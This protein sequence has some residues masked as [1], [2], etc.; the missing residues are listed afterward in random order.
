METLAGLATILILAVSV[1]FLKRRGDVALHHLDRVRREH[2]EAQRTLHDLQTVVQ[3]IDESVFLLDRDERIVFLNRAAETLFSAPVNSGQSFSPIA[4]QL[5][6]QPL[7]DEILSHRAESLAQT[8]VK[9][10]R[11]FQVNVRAGPPQT[12]CA[13]MI[14]V[15]EVTELQRL[16]RVRRD[17]VANI[18]HE[19]RT[20]VTTLRLLADTLSR[21]IDPHSPAN[22]WIAKLQGQ[23]DALHQLTNEL[24]D[25]ALIESGQMP[26]K[27]VD[28]AVTDLI[29]QVVELFRAQAERKG[30]VIQM[31][32]TSDLHVLADPVGAQRVLGN[33]LHN[34]IKFTSTQGQVIVRARLVADNI[35]FQVIDNGIGIPARDLP[36][37]FERF[38][39][40]ERARMPDE[41]RGTGLGL[42]IAKHIVEGHGGRIWAESIEGRGSTFYFTLPTGM[43]RQP[44]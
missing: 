32:V 36:R 6:I 7:I 37:I 27:L 3:N 9:D 25:L 39:R 12:T 1:W 8:V 28:L 11:A 22:E 41:G 38:Y 13:A 5:Q 2:A 34:A 31:D 44:K 19:L 21:E 35:E 20:P 10:D 43:A 24:M 23:I 14:L 15:S 17:F 30:I 16:G 4:W 29:T 40:V 18:S 42:A 26:I 33:L